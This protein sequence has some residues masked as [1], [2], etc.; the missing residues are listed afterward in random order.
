MASV[1]AT[2]TCAICGPFGMCLTTGCCSRVSPSANRT[3]SKSH[4]WCHLACEPWDP[5]ADGHCHGF[6]GADPAAPPQHVLV[7]MLSSVSS[8]GTVGTARQ[9][10]PWKCWAPPVP[11][12]LGGMAATMPCLALKPGVIPE[13]RGA[14]WGVHTTAGHVPMMASFTTCR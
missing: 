2:M 10:P 7:A 12:A 8:W 5:A 9:P 6:P 13:G 4:V 11:R 1:P 3:Q 14:I